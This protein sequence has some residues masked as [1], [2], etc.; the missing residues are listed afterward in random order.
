MENQEPVNPEQDQSSLDE[1]LNADPTVDNLGGETQ[2]QNIPLSAHIKERRKRQEAESKRQEA[3]EKLKFYE[4]QQ[5]AAEDESKYD[6]A[7]KED[8]SKLQRDTLRLVEETKWAKDNPDKYQK[9]NEELPNFLKRR[10]NLAQAIDAASN[11]YEEAWVLM[12]AL[13]PRQQQQDVNQT[14]RADSPGSPSGV[15]KAGALNEAVDLMN[16]SD[17]EFNKWRRQQRSK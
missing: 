7:T 8:L 15:P 12:N 2:E 4:E 13:S 10:P 14:K 9:I 3:E 17:D 11:R 5:K 1:T 6:S 16:M